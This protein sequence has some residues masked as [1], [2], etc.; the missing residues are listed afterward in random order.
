MYLK[1][2]YFNITLKYSSAK[3]IYWCIFNLRDFSLKL[4]YTSFLLRQLHFA[5]WHPHDK[6]SSKSSILDLPQLCFDFSYSCKMAQ[7]ESR[8]ISLLSTLWGKLKKLARISTKW[9]K[10]LF[11]RKRLYDYAGSNVCHWKRK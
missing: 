2:N 3:N 4:I 6:L 8:E 11:L 10:Y 7:G 1:K 5:M 9:V